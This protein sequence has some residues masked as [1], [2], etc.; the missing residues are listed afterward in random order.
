MSDYRQPTPPAGSRGRLALAC[1]ATTLLL[2]SLAA[3]VLAGGPR[4][5]TS[6][7]AATAAA[8]AQFKHVAAE[9]Q[10][11]IARRSRQTAIQQWQRA[12]HEVADPSD[13]PPTS[14]RRAIASVR[15][16]VYR[17]LDGYLPYEVDRLTPGERSELK[18]TSSTQLAHSLLGRPPL[19]PPSGPRPPEGRPVDVLTTFARGGREAD[20]YTEI[21]YGQEQIGFYLTL[22]RG[23]TYGW[24]VAAFHA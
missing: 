23:G 6:D 13:P 3:L 14:Q 20:V 11:S 22:R 7:A 16:V 19:I 10:A 18:Q 2:G 5:R 24:L 12:H 15:R 4:P 17:W 9:M 21:A 1:F 8:A